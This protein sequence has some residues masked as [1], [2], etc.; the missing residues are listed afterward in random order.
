M[1]FVMFT[2]DVDTMFD[3]LAIKKNCKIEKKF[4]QACAIKLFDIGA[5]I[6]QDFATVIN[7]V[8]HFKSLSVT[9]TLSL[10]FV[11]NVGAYRAGLN[12]RYKTNC[13]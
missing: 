10:I 12:S 5:C 4:D 7:S 3:I 6:I 11:G 13:D 9:F 1:A 2:F 8:F